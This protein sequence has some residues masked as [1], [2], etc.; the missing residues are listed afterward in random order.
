MRALVR[1]AVAAAALATYGAALADDPTERA[2]DPDPVRWGLGIERAFAV[3]SADTT[4]P[5]SY[6][7]ELLLGYEEGLLTLQLGSTASDLLAQRAYGDL[8]FTWSL[9]RFELGA[10]LPVALWQRADFSLLT[11]AGV[12]GP[13]VA[14]VAATALGDLRLGAKAGLLS[15]TSFPVAVAAVLD[16]RLPTGDPQ[17]FTSDGLAVVPSAVVSRTFGRLRL[18]GQ[19]GYAFRGQGQYAQLVVRDGLVY[20]AAASFQLPAAWKID[21]WRAIAELTGGWTR[22]D[23]AGDARYRSPLSARAGVR[24]AVWKDLAV[25]IGGGGGIGSDGYGREAWR[26]FLGIRWEHVATDRDGDGVPDDRDA[27]PDVPGPAAQAGCPDPDVDHD[28]VPNRDDACP[29]EPGPAD[30]DGCPDR[31]ADTIPDREDRCPD[32]PGPAQND[33]CPI[34]LDEPTVEIETE[35]LSLRDAITFDTGKDTIRKTSYRVLDEIAAILQQHT[36]IARIRVEGHTDD[37]GAAA[38]NKDLSQRRAT[39]VVTYLVGK[40][41]ARERLVAVGYG[42]ERPVASNATALGRAKNRRVEFTILPAAEGGR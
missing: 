38:Y 33:G 5:G 31:D 29:N 41:V 12:Q 35:R 4:L 25:E 37:V 22:G 21:R 23:S 14:P 3:E 32:E 28:G 36:E 8:L 34:G 30:L 19:V 40:G 7:A 27:C 16:L 39:S 18:D 10:D 20:G 9:G 2:F 6:Q 13:L 11:D 26:V 15:Q 42:F 17:A 1:H 24:A